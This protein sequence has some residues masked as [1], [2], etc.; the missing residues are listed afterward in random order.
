MEPERIPAS[1]VREKVSGDTALLVC[2]YDDNDKFN[3]FY[4]DGAI[5]LDEFKSR[6]GDLDKN[7]DIFFYCA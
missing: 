4:L 1:L 2:A 3:Q 7:M 5:S 6:S